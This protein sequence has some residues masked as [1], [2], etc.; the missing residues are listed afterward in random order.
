MV[1]TDHEIIDAEGVSYGL[2]P[3]CKWRRPR[4][5]DRLLKGFCTQHFRLMRR[6]V[7]DAVGGYDRAYPLAMDYDLCLKLSE[8]TQIAHL[9]EVLYGYRRHADSLSATR[10]REQR[11][12]ARRAVAAAIERRGMRQ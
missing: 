12:C 6:S 1:Y 5:A 4:A 8:V 11:E 3:T 2:G 7:Y 9:D 10:G